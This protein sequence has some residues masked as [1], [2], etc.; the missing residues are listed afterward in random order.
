MENS[1]YDFFDLKK[2]NRDWMDEFIIRMWWLCIHVERRWY[3]AATLVAKPQQPSFSLSLI[4]TDRGELRERTNE[5][6][7]VF[8]CS[9][10]P[11]DRHT[12]GGTTRG[13]GGDGTSFQY[14]SEA[15]E[16][17][18]WTHD[19]FETSSKSCPGFCFR[20]GNFRGDGEKQKSDSGRFLVFVSQ[21]WQRWVNRLSLWQ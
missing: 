4:T 7:W 13:A 14:R 11:I 20:T 15:A 16:V 2:Q 17:L 5:C 1:N 18:L 10:L 6:T 19:C 3:T 21:F 9:R 12:E 8:S